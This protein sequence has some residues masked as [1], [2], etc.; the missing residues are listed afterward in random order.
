VPRSLGSRMRDHEPPRPLSRL[1]TLDG[2][3]SGAP[4]TQR[5]TRHLQVAVLLQKRTVLQKRW[6]HTSQQ[7]KH[8]EQRLEEIE[9]RLRGLAAEMTHELGRSSSG[10]VT[11]T[12]DAEEEVVIRYGRSR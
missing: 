2:V 1:R 5:A 10:R 6:E 3:H 9:A 7:L 4:K 12:E 11:S 8:I